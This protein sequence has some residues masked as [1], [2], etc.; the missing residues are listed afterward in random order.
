[1]LEFTADSALGTNQVDVRLHLA[2]YVYHLD[3]ATI[4]R[5]RT[6]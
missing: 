1:M 4:A 3:S 6:R 5:V 2:T